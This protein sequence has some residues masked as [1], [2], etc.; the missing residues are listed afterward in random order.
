M[1]KSKARRRRIEW[2]RKK[3]RVKARVRSRKTRR[4][5]TWVP[6]KKR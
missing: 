5:K 3:F 1:I 2:A 6:G 4:K